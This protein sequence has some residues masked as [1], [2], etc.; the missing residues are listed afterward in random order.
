[1][2][3]YS[4]YRQGERIGSPDIEL[5]AGGPWP[6][7][8]P[9]EFSHVVKWLFTFPPGCD[10]IHFPV[11]RLQTQHPSAFIA[12][13]GDFNHLT[14]DTALPNSQHVSCPTGEERS[15]NLLCANRKDAYSSFPLPHWVGQTRIWCTSTLVMCLESRASLQPQSVI[16][17]L[18]LCMQ[19]RER[20]GCVDHTE[21]E[22]NP[23]FL[24]CPHI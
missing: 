17:T 10:I 18:T 11:A 23:H 8:L 5:F 24:C 3:S 4:Y 1:M 13:S 7:Y 19:N 14:M 2:Q 15:L 12:I 20:W 16:I 9:L 6:Y 21:S 22:S